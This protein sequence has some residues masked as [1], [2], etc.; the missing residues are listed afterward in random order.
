VV[1]GLAPLGPDEAHRLIDRLRGHAVLTGTRG[2]EPVDLDALATTLS[3][4]GNLLVARPEIADL[5]LN[6]LLATPTGAVAVDWR[7]TVRR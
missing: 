2:R 4:I 3:A 5:D 7:I 6:P 1:F